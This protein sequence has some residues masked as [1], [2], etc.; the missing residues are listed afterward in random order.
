M[1]PPSGRDYWAGC[2]SF[3]TAGC[4]GTPATALPAVV[5]IGYELGVECQEALGVVQ[6]AYSHFTVS[7]HAYRCQ[8]LST[9]KAMNLRWISIRI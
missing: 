3:R 9:P 6:H 2:G 5:Q 1:A 4:G 7:V 8:L